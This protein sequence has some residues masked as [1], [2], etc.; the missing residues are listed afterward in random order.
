MAEILKR[1]GSGPSFRSLVEKNLLGSIVL[2]R[3][4]NRTYR[5]DEIAWDKKV[6]DEFEGRHGE[7]ISYLKVRVFQNRNGLSSTKQPP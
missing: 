1:A 4:N 2:T 7:K 6:T 5:I 3:Y